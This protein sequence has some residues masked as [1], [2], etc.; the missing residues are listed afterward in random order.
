MAEPERPK[1]ALIG[2]AIL[3]L[4]LQLTGIILMATERVPVARAVPLLVIGMFLAFAP[5]FGQ[6]IHKKK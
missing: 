1:K 4:L 6:L 2:V 3:G 5:I